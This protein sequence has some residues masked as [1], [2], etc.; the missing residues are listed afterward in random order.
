MTDTMTSQD[1]DL[2]HPAYSVIY[3][4]GKD[5]VKLSL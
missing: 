1:I 5:K 2:W 4:Q 3:V